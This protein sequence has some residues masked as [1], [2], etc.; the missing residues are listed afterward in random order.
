MAAKKVQTAEEWLKE[1]EED[2]KAQ[3]NRPPSDRGIQLISDEYAA[4]Q[5]FID[6]ENQLWHAANWVAD[7]MRRDIEGT[8]LRASEIKDL[9]QVLERK[10][11]VLEAADFADERIAEEQSENERQFAEQLHGRGV[12]KVHYTMRLDKPLAESIDEAAK[13]LGLK[14]T[15]VVREALVEWLRNSKKGGKR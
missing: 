7:A 14:R 15:E 2:V 6:I 12:E 1:K 9:R 11:D 4:L 5:R 13:G 8:E 3:L 10:N